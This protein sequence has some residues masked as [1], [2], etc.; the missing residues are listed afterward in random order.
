MLAVE[1]GGEDGGEFLRI[2]T[3][4]VHAVAV[5]MRARHIER[6]DP[7]HRTEQMLR[8][9]GVEFVG[10]DN[11]G[12]ARELEVFLRDDQM[13]IAGLRAHRAIA[14]DELNLARRAHF[15][16]NRAAVTSAL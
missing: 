9:A 14:I 6:L 13:Q 7:A 15:K 1:F 4:E 11:V 16:R 10:A 8:R 5:R 2:E 12:T 3:A